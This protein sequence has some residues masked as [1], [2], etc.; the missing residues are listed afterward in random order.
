[1]P[2][3]FG[4]DDGLNAQI[5]ELWDSAISGSTRLTYN[6]AL[7]C[8][9]TF[10]ALNRLT[11]PGVCLPHI[12]EDCLIYFVTYCQKS[13]NLKHQSINLYLAGIRHYYIR[14]RGYDPFEKAILLPIILR[15]IKKS[16]CNV[17]K[18]R[19]PIT[20]S[21]LKE[22]CILLAKGVFSPF[23]DI[24]LQ[25]SFKLAFFGFL[26]CGE[27]TCRHLND[28]FS[29]VLIQDI[30]MDSNKQFFI[31][32]LR[33][34]KCDPFRQGINIT[35]YENIV[36]RP[37]Y[38]MDRYLKLRFNSGALPQYPLFVED[39]YKS[40]P[41]K[42]DTFISLLRQLLDRLG[43]NMCRFIDI[44]PCLGSVLNAFPR[45]VT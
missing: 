4:I 33:S 21:I 29:T 10:L 41:L 14:F 18:E 35:I 28:E 36:F 40:L 11:S 31:F 39:E 3:T 7:R 37:V 30:T 5:E 24:M 9:K 34:S 19:L 32:H 23:V 13:L 6:S 12:D 17:T 42:R 27:F 45:Y 20:S 16:Q 15:G 1:M 44:N 25:C 26:R 43:Y 2:S 22:L 8:F 38:T